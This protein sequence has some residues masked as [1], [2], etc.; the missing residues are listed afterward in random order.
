MIAEDK[1][2]VVDI[3]GT[4]CGS[5]KEGETYLQ[6]EPKMDVV[7]KLR[8]Y[9]EDGFYVIL[10]TARQ[11]RTY[12]GNVGKINANTAKVLFEWL[13]VNKIP[14]DEVH[15]G[16]PWCGKR[17]FYID[18]KAIRPSEFVNLTYEEIIKLINNEEEV[19]Q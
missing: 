1:V 16:K 11:M 7:N 8:Q 18:D 2:L 15:F 3:D 6:I 9:K 4:L 12:Q 10:F 5:K 17:G 19:G 13:D 14:Y